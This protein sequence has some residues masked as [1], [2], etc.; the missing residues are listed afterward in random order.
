MIPFH[1]FH[2]VNI[3]PWPLIN[4]LNILN[5]IFN[6]IIFIKFY[7]NPLITF[8]L[9]L[10]LLLISLT[11]LNWWR[12]ITREGAFQGHHTKNVLTGLKI[13]IIIF[14]VSEIIF[15]L[16]FFWRFFHFRLSPEIELGNSWPPMNIFIFNPYQIPLLNTLILLTSGASITWCHHLIIKKIYNISIITLITTIFLGII[17]SFFQIEEYVNSYY[18]INDRVFGSIFYISTGFHGLHVFIGTI[19]LLVNLI[20][21]YKSQLNNKHHFS[22]EAAAW[23]WHFV[24]VVWIYLFTFI[25]WW[26]W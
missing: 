16:R 5:L 12:D 4:S 8:S 23:Y 3:R 14:I 20:R 7:Q 6:S 21:I 2:I 17:F 24:D 9:K 18:N 25:Y 22:F 1:S 13:R 11:I 10:S 19:F 15:F 26:F